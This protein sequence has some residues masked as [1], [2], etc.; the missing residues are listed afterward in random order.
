MGGYYF[1]TS[2]TIHQSSRLIVSLSRL[3]LFTALLLLSASIGFGQTG[4]ATITGTVT[5]S[6]GAVLAEAAVSVRNLENGAE[7]KTVSSSTG[8]FTVTQLPIG[9]YDLNI[10]SPGFKTYTHARFHLA[11]AQVMREDVQLEVGQTSESV[12][13]TAD[14]SLLKTDTTQLSQNVTLAQL[15]NLPIL[16]VG[17]T[18]SGFRDPFA[19]V[20]L[21]PG[22][23]YNNGSNIASGNTAATSSMVINGTPANTYQT[24]LDGM[25]MNPTGPRLIGAQ[26]QTQPS[27]DAIEE[28]AVQT[29]NFAAEFGA[30]GGAMITMTT[31]SGTNQ[32]HGSAY[33]YGT[34][35]ALNAHQPYTGLRSKVR[36]NDFGFTLGG[37]VK[38]PK[39]YD[40][41]NKTF[42]FFS[43]EMFKQTNIVNNSV[44]V[45]TAAYRV[46]DFSNLITAENRLIT[47]AGGNA[48]DGF[49]NTIQSG[50]I[51]DPL[52]ETTINGKQNRVK[53]PDNKIPVSRF[54]PVAVRVLSLVP[55]PQ[56]VNFDRGL[57]SDNY[58][59]TYDTSR[60]SSIPSIKIDQNI[61]SKGRLSVYYQRTETF[62]PRTPTGADPL[63]DTI[64]AGVTTYSA[65]KTG[66]VNYDYTITPR[67]LLHLGAGWNDSDFKLEAP[68]T[69]FDAFAQLGLPGQ[70]E[71]H[72]FP[73]LQ[74]G[75]NTTNNQVGGM[76]LLGN[77]YATKSFERRPSG[78][79]SATYVVGSHTFKAGVDGRI[80]K[81]PNYVRSGPNTNTTGGYSFGVNYTEQPYLLGIQTNQGFDGFQLASFLLGGVSVANQVAP[82]ALSNSKS[83]WGVY[84]QDTWK[85]TRKL[86]LD[87]GLRWDLGT[88]AAEQYGRNGSIGLGIANPSA[89]GRLGATQFEETCNCNFANNYTKAFGPRLGVAYQIDSKTVF[90]AGFG[91]V[92]NAT[93]TASGSSN[94]LSTSNTVTANSG[95]IVSLFQ[96]GLPAAG[97]QGVWPSFNPGVGQAPGSVIP[98][99]ALLDR[100]AGRP[101]RLAQWS[102]GLQREFTRNTVVEASYVGNRGTWWTANGLSTLN[103]LSESTLRAYGFNDFRSA[104]ESALLTTNVGNL[105]PAQ[106]STLAAR[107][108]TGQPYA[109][110]PT[111]QTVRQSLLAYPQYTGNGLAG[112]PLG[113]TWYD[114]F[115]LNVTQR[116]SHGLSFNLNYTWAKNLDTISLNSNSYDIFNRQLAKTYSNNDVPHQ[117]RITAQYVVPSMKSLGVNKYVAY[118]LADWGIGAYLS[119][120]SA[121]ALARPTS[122]GTVP[123]NQFLGR[124]PGTAQLKKDA[125]GEY[126]S[127]YSVNWVD[128]DGKHHTDPLDINCHCYDPTKTQVFNPNAWENVPNGQWA[129][130]TSVLRF[131]RGIRIPQENAN[132]SRN[133][134]FGREGRYNL[135]VRVEFN[136]IFNRMILPQPTVVAGVGQPAINFANPPTKITDTNNPNVGLYSGGFG[137]FNVLGGIG[138]QRTGTFV[139]RFTF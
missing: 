137:T 109:N 119:Y 79:V 55:N 97:V 117:F 32:Y 19:S 47:T 37:P 78:T 33:D 24:R 89:S 50:T 105:T 12:T 51:F 77:V 13:V 81:F 123:L 132:L 34:N 133:F 63:P 75:E 100:N 120:Q 83:Q 94:A 88:Y 69:N 62:S 1:A 2:A 106:R 26:M 90:R 30:A 7:F 82:T 93:S 65:G 135:N 45:P 67:L 17:S 44:S 4:L 113:N 14:A 85:V 15:N 6:S 48:L 73:V 111:N 92:Y 139:G 60:T 41:T 27:T 57:V 3:L 39:L 61:G 21:V 9:D 136:N 122:N 72:Y 11:S 66:R 46:G 49:G 134:R 10:T 22:V 64:T 36:Q 118:A 102:I 52:T 58:T 103:A 101:A 5:D 42:F 115:Q 125:F 127:P 54:D 18:N 23:N 104:S 56:G 68:V 80:E 84:A 121:V 99:P 20:R 131:M 112:A 107:G 28:V 114:A 91:I 108:I 29:S 53:F 96:D 128:Y 25:T 35:E 130:D 74:T 16:V 86:T 70:V 95:Q 40:G 124:G 87:Y 126:M 138:N 98:M 116:F 71:S 59:G 43:W 8:N 38:I 129:N 76:S 31:K 110:F